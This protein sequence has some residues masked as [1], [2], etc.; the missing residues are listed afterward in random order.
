MLRLVLRGAST[1]L[2]A[3]LITVA[4][5]S[6]SAA[7]ACSGSDCYTTA[8][9]V[10][11][12]PAFGN[13]IFRFPQALAFSPGGSYVF[14]G[15]Q[16]SGIVQKFTYTGDYQSGWGVG[17][18][19]GY[20]DHGQ[21][22]R[23]GTL[24]GLATDRANHLFVLDSQNDRVQVFRSD[25]GTWLASFGSHGLAPAQ[26]FNLGSN[27]GAGGIAVFQPSDP[28]GPTGPPVVYIADQYNHRI[29]KFTLTQSAAGA[30]TSP[31][32][33]AGAR[34][35]PSNPETYN[36]VASPTPDTTWGHKGD[37]SSTGTCSDPA[38]YLA[39]Y[40]PQG[41][42]VGPIADSAG[43]H[44]VYVADDDNHRIVEYD[45]EGNYL[46]Q[47]GSYGNGAGQF[48]YPYDVGVDGQNLLDVADNNNHRIDQ[49]N[50]PDLIFRQMWGGFGSGPGSF[51]YVRALGAL[52]DD[53][54][55]GVY[56]AD[57]ANN[58]VQGWYHGSGGSPTYVWGVAGRGPGYVTRP[59]N[60]A[61]DTAGNIYV[62][63][64]FDSRIE[65]LSPSG[66]YL[67]Q[68]GY[69]SSLSG[70]TA[71]HTGNGEF[72]NPRGVAYDAKRDALWVADTGNNRIQEISLTG[73]S[74]GTWTGFSAPSGVTVDAAGNVYVAD[75]RNNR[76]QRYDGSTWSTVADATLTAPRGVAYDDQAGVLYA[77]DTGGNRIVI[78]DGGPSWTP[79]GTPALSSPAGVAIDAG[80]RLLYVADTGNNQILRQDLSAV[81]GSWDA[82]GSDGL[83]AGQ[84]IGPSGVAL[85]PA[86]SLLVADTYAN[87][88]QRFT[89][90]SATTPPP[91]PPSFTLSDNPTTV[92]VTRGARTPGTSTITITP[93]GGFSGAVT[94]ST[95]CP[96]AVSCSFSP[97]PATSSSNLT[98]KAGRKAATTSGTQLT[99]TGASGSLTPATTAVTLV[100][101]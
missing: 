91:P 80:R 90:T 35:D 20:A 46:N 76:V 45:P 61:T 60:T 65:K 8:A 28:N 81:S 87:R 34:G 13:S 67:D 83:S 1:L 2:V 52:A 43:R 30:D 98:V 100:V 26:G 101:K 85:D 79:V 24:G 23:M 89:F 38:N 4:V 69:L 16:Y 49:F 72:D 53:P 11:T 73:S 62:A 37:C 74:L 47:V 12:S 21:V 25:T 50:A 94:L 15:D 88:I 55:G 63:D 22:G 44:D 59:A 84:F 41:I 95:N 57:T 18:V 39:L 32:L 75:T 71:P 9:A 93:A 97:N 31:V 48:E 66:A 40:Y 17:Y 70:F 3:A 82:W 56:V 5:A 86:G 99:I 68:F 27:T 78:N 19:G 10:G 29:Q 7:A 54:Q 77:A 58:R 92:T 96:A 36:T 33:P 51:E 14:V 42:T 6:T 64:T